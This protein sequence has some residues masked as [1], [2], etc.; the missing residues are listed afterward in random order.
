MQNGG[1]SSA[2][3]E[4]R[5]KLIRLIGTTALAIV[6]GVFEEVADPFGLDSQSDRLSANIYN[7]ITSPLYGAG[8]ILRVG[9]EE[10]KSRLGQSNVSV[11]LIDD[12]YL[13][14]TDQSWPLD[15]RRYQRILRRLVDA[16]A[17]AV[18]VDIY[19]VQ[20]TETRRGRI[21]KL[22]TNA[23]CLAERSACGTV[24][25]GW[26]CGNAENKPACATPSPT[27][28]T[29]IIFAGTMNDP[30]PA[31]DDVAPP[32]VAL[33]GMIG[34]DTIYKLRQED[35]D[36]KVHD[37]AAWALYKAWCVRNREICDPGWFE[38][39][40]APA[41]FLHW[42]FAPDQFMTDTEYGLGNDECQV[43]ATSFVGR[44]SQSVN[45]FRWNFIR[46][47]NDSRIAPCPYNT[48]I[49]LQL[50]NNLPED[51]LVK[52]FAGKI[53]ILGAALK[54]HPDYR[55]S[56]VHDYVPGAFWHAMAADNL[57]EFSDEYLRHEEDGA[58]SYLEPVGLSIIFMLQALLTW[59]IQRRQ[60]REDLGYRA[61]LELDLMH[62]AFTICLISATVLWITG[63]MRWSPANWIGF[64]ML[65]FLIDFKPVAA[66]PR[67]CWEIFPSMRMTNQSFRVAS[68]FFRAAV[69]FFLI[70]LAGYVI[71][72]VP[73]AFILAYV[74]HVTAISATF[75]I[76]YTAAL[77]FFLWRIIGGK[78]T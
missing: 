66:V 24:D 20:N 73:H 59:V 48:Q 33:A 42:G 26:R 46:G 72:V 30:E 69:M 68:R 65:M 61:R 4:S 14:K 21:K 2:R 11:L 28:G 5:G 19:F 74:E 38:K 34:E 31:V 39:E 64:A 54:N 75:L 16:G 63:F 13:E 51:D 10:F 71:L 77:M 41:M 44:L 43:Q 47:F 45:I 17:S 56:P 55:W 3:D 70:L 53:V 49:K 76:L 60:D 52:L 8:S 67:Y 7:T 32:K 23:A 35:V 27:D 9:D 25:E 40:P 50:F 12:D 36:G 15:P 78:T 6:L 57:I 37:T 22:F 18:F 1:D 29:E 58:T 62:G